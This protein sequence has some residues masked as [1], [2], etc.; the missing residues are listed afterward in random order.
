MSTTGVQVEPCMSMKSLRK[1]I[2]FQKNPGRRTKKTGKD[3]VIYS[4]GPLSTLTTLPRFPKNPPI[5]TCF[6]N[7]KKSFS[8]L[9]RSEIARYSII[10]VL[11]CTPRY[12]SPYLVRS[13]LHTFQRD[14]GKFSII[15]HIC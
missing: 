13:I 14:P 15:F 6:Q 11:V 4:M 2:E 9:L 3:F 1:G 12:F 7:L 5:N 8:Y 10:K